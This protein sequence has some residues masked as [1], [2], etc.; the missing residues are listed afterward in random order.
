MPRV[1]YD[2]AS[3]NL[4]KIPLTR[5]NALLYTSSVSSWYQLGKSLNIPKEMLSELVEGTY[6]DSQRRDK[7]IMEWLKT[8]NPSWEILYDAV[9]KSKLADWKPADVKIYTSYLAK[10]EKEYKRLIDGFEEILPQKKVV[11]DKIR[12]RYNQLKLLEKKVRVWSKEDINWEVDEHVQYQDDF[13]VQLQQLQ[14]VAFATQKLKISWKSA[15]LAQLKI[16]LKTI[17]SA[18][19]WAMSF[20]YLI[21]STGLRVILYVYCL[22]PLCNRCYTFIIQLFYNR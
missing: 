18:S 9:E 4:Q 22:I 14:R 11:L 13:N 16:W 8:S 7:I 12:E 3:F 1:L 6:L 2:I 15:I 20:I 5:R 10:L 19:I 21:V 17:I